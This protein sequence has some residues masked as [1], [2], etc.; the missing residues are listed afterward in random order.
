MTMFEEIH[1]VTRLEEEIHRMYQNEA[2]QLYKRDDFTSESDMIQIK[3]I[4]RKLLTKTRGN[5]VSNN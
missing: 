4:T 5:L 2:R 3:I 1:N